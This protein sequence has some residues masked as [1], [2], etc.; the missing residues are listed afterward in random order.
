MYVFY[1][2]LSLNSIEKS[3]NHQ[4]AE[5]GLQDKDQAYILIILAG[6]RQNKQQKTTELST[7]SVVRNKLTQVSQK[8]IPIMIQI[9][10]IKRLGDLC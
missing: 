2:Y 9:K 5:I 10:T 3:F 8:V 7:C 1:M 6:L 4:K